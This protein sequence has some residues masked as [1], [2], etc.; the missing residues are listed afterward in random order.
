MEKEL[1]HV[2]VPLEEGEDVEELERRAEVMDWTFESDGK[3]VAR[4]V[5]TSRM[6]KLLVSCSTPS[7]DS[8][9]LRDLSFV[10]TRGG[11][12]VD[13]EFTDDEF[14]GRARADG[15]VTGLLR[16]EICFRLRCGDA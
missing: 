4:V 10:E 14:Y 6:P 7:S 5:G 2:G 11:L 8:C 1:L 3:E 9:D 16:L 15:N 12:V 13:V